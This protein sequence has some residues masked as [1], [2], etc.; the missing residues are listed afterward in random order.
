MK[1]KKNN[2]PLLGLREIKIFEIGTV[3]V[4]DEAMHVAYN[5]GDKIIE[6]NLD[7]FCKDTNLN[8]KLEPRAYGLAPAFRMWPLFPFIVRDI[9]VWVPGEVE[10]EKVYKVIKEN[11]GDMVVRGPELFDTFTKDSKTSYA[12][13]IVFQ[14]HERTLIDEEINELMEKIIKALKNKFEVDIR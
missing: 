6:L 11:A 2:L 12:F 14:S 4:P 8:F 3:W 10:S 5:D 1:L 7:D 13:R 9:A